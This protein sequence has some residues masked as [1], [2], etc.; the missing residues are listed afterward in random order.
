M[1]FT[2]EQIARAQRAKSVEELMALAK[3]EQIELTEEEA[4]TYF[5]KT[6]AQSGKLDD[7]DLDLVTGGG[8]GGGSSEPEVPADYGF[9]T[10]QRVYLLN[11]I[12]P[13]CSKHGYYNPSTN[14]V[15]E[16]VD[17]PGGKYRLHC[18]ICHGT[19][20]WDHY[21]GDPATKMRRV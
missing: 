14:F 11:G 3:E 4:E 7:D 1:K 17:Y 13:E 10:G 6:A 15:L 12:C 9:P 5:A 21:Y 20:Q 8:C 16:W 19:H 18:E 2:A